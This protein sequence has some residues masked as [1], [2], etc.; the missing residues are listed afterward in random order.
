MKGKTG[1]KLFVAV[2]IFAVVICLGAF[3]GCKQVNVKYQL[4]FETNGGTECATI[5]SDDVSTIKIPSN[6]TRE[7]YIFD[8]W[9]WD[10]GEWEKPFTINS[11]LDQHVSEYMNLTVYAKWKG[12]DVSVV[13]QQF[14]GNGSAERKIEYGAMYTLPVP[15]LTYEDKGFCGWALDGTSVPLTDGE[16]ASLDVCD[17]L[18]ATFT[19]VW[20]TGKVTLTFDAGDGRA[21]KGTAVVWK[22]EK[23]GALPKASLSGYEFIGWFTEREGGR[24]IESDDTVELS[25]NV[26]LY[27]H[28]AK[29]ATATVIYDGNGATGGAMA[30]DS[31]T[32]GDT[33]F[34]SYNKFSRKGYTFAGWTCGGETYYDGQTVKLGGGEHVFKAVWK[35]KNIDILFDSGDS[36]AEGN[37]KKVSYTNGA[38]YTLPQCGYT[39]EYKVCEGWKMSGGKQYSLGERISDFGTDDTV[40]ILI[41]VWR[42]VRYT[43]CIKTAADTPLSECVRV[44]AEG[45]KAVELSAYCKEKAGYD[46]YWTVDNGNKAGQEIYNSAINL[47]LTDGEEISLTPHYQA[48]SYKVVYKTGSM[49]Y[50]IVGIYELEY[51]EE[52]TVPAMTYENEGFNFAGWRYSGYGLDEKFED[53]TFLPQDSVKNLTAYDDVELEAVAQWTPLTYTVRLH[54][55]DGTERTKDVEVTYGENCSLGAGWLS[56]TDKYK[57]AGYRCGGTVYSTYKDKDACATQGAVVDMYALWTYKY[58]GGGTEQSPFIIDCAEALKNLPYYLLADNDFDRMYFR[59]AGDI[60]MSGEEFVPIGWYGDRSFHGVFDGDGH[61]IKGLSITLP[62]D[63][64][65]S[66]YSANIGFICYLQGTSEK[67]SEIKDVIFEDCSLTASLDNGE[68]CVGLV[69]GNL[70]SAKVS[71]CSVVNGSVTVESDKRVNVG[72]VIGSG[73][74]LGSTDIENCYFGGTISVKAQNATV[75]GLGAS[76]CVAYACGANTQMMVEAEYACI[77]GL[78]RTS[79]SGYSVT[80]AAITSDNCEIYEGSSS[81]TD[82]YY[83]SQSAFTLNGVATSERTDKNETADENLKDPSWVSQ[84]IPALRTTLWTMADGYPVLGARTLEERTISTAAELLALSGKNITEKYVLSADIEL[85]GRE[86]TPATVYGEFDG[87][88]HTV[89]NFTVTAEGAEGGMFT[90]NYGVIRNLCVKNLLLTASNDGGMYV[91]GIVGRNLGTISYCKSEGE[92]AAFVG[93]YLYIGGIAG[94]N[95]G[96]IYGCYSDCRLEGTATEPEQRG[97]IN[98]PSSRTMMFGIAYNDGGS[99]SSCYTCG[100]YIASATAKVLLGG[101]SQEG[102]NCFSLANLSYNTDVKEKQV[103]AVASK[104]SGCSSQKINGTA[105]QGYSETFLKNPAYITGTIGMEQYVSDEHLADN[106]YACWKITSGALPKLYF[107][108]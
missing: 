80:Q 87:N 63:Y 60:D 78:S 54:S 6:P 14:D 17:F 48:H 98:M 81:A 50:K 35:G 105:V 25:G 66:N 70:Y 44:P 5:K 93:R 92:I 61:R 9:F 51:D 56:D 29:Q 53:K 8:G 59:L 33:N 34:L 62:S 2:F 49:T 12:V 26:T 18:S 96:S 27:A 43:V 77:F 107:E 57:F 91:G 75:A 108:E 76:Y 88:G 65:D 68:A 103:W 47:A 21:D 4:A 58:S 19:P 23:F 84:N 20:R 102:V 85:N 71:G 89:N 83:S 101:V 7:N 1:K 82:S 10:D 46:F 72:G 41:A 67:P 106:I 100:D 104:L 55:N 64:S 45:C 90:V 94:I 24:Q 22:G 15:E 86:W 11:I 3:F 16:G 52:H 99:I 39:C 97:T 40:V 31:F 74:G 69:A 95:S 73:K 79:D 28:Y 30:N 42:P 36:G 37:M 38:G 32:A 13:L